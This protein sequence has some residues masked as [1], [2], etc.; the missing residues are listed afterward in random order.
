MIETF[1]DTMVLIGIIL[2]GIGVLIVALGAVFST[3]HALSRSQEPF[4][5]R[6][7]MLRDNLGRSILIGLEFIIAGDIIRSVVVNPTVLNV[8]VLGLIVLIRTFLSMMLQLEVEGR[9]P[10][11]NISKQK[12]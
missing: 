10:W 3:L 5:V 2:D 7:R 9:W 12:S 6:Y 11:Q 4:A 8:A 1:R